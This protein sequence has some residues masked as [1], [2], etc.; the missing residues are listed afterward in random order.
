VVTSVYE[1]S[2]W[3]RHNFPVYLPQLLA[4]EISLSTSCSEVWIPRIQSRNQQSSFPHNQSSA[5]VTATLTNAPRQ[6]EFPEASF[7]W[8]GTSWNYSLYIYCHT[9]RFRRNQARR[10]EG[11][12]FNPLK[13][14]S[15]DNLFNPTGLLTKTEA[16]KEIDRG[17]KTPKKGIL[18]SCGL[19]RDSFLPI[20]CFPSSAL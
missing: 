17:P 20:I 10:Y 9:W 2:K 13:F 8:T 18:H 1:R 3:C 11:E 4:I 5:T 19:Q 7:P 14:R 12:L 16:C 15:V 6:W